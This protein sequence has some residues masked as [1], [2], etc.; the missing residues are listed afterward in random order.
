MQ[1]VTSPGSIVAAGAHTAVLS[2][3]FESWIPQ[4]RGHFAQHCTVAAGSLH[5]ESPALVG[6]VPLLAKVP[7]T[8]YKIFESQWG[9]SSNAACG[10]QALEQVTPLELVSSHAEQRPADHSGLEQPLP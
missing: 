4:C 7:V 2:V 6:T 10:Q 8:S 3:L 9:C 5:I 1:H